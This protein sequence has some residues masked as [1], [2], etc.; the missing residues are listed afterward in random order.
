MQAS[1]TAANQLTQSVTSTVQTLVSTGS[2]ST[3]IAVL[4]QTIQLLYSSTAYKQNDP[5]VTAL[6]QSLST[7][8]QNAEQKNPGATASAAQASAAQ[9]YY[10]SALQ[11]PDTTVSVTAAKDI[12][13]SVNS[14]VANL[15]A[16]G[17]FST[18]NTL[19]EQTIQAIK[20]SSAFTSGNA[21]VIALIGSLTALQTN[22]ASIDPSLRAV[23]ASG[24]SGPSGPS[25][26]GDGYEYG[27]ADTPED[28]EKHKIRMRIKQ[29]LKTGGSRKKS[30]R[31]ISNRRKSNK[32]R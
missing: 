23:A 14:S 17:S 9:S 18:A 20:A 31:T 10:M 13:T 25:D 5:T 22:T 6:I 2:F 16:T 26:E 11:S 29:A 30:N 27:Y 28:S 32:K 12:V 3:A 21:D 8:L 1:V 24:P 19:I 15:V 7:T 4:T